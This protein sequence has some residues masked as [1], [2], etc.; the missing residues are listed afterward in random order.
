[1]KSLLALL[2]TFGSQARALETVPLVD[3]RRY[4]GQWYEI[5]SFPSWF[6]NNCVA[7]TANYALTEGGEIEVVNRCRKRSLDG[8]IKE[9]K[10]KARVVD[11]DTNSKLEV[12]FFWPFWGDYWIIELGENY[13]YSV[14]SEP[15]KKYLWI[16]SRTPKM[17]ENLYRSIVARLVEK[18]FD[19]SKLIRT[20][21]P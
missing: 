16:L 21:H 20:L 4:V 3:L 1:M 11:K 10:G 15:K 13:E 2:F 7:S 17:E 9:V 14:V 5:A 18:G 6:Q 12:Q 19:T 8:D